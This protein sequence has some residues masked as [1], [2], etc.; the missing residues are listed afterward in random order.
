MDA[1]GVSTLSCSG[2]DR[3]MTPVAPAPTSRIAPPSLA[4]TSTNPSATCTESALISTLTVKVVP[5]TIA[6]RRGV[7]TLKCCEGFLSIWKRIEPRSCRIRV[8][9]AFDSG[10]TVIR[11]LGPRVMRCAPLNKA[12]R[13]PAAVVTILPTGRTWLAFAEMGALPGEAIRTTPATSTSFQSAA[14]ASLEPRARSAV[15]DTAS[16]VRT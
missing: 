11:L 9:P 6:A 5:F 2:A 13:P 12:A 1:R 10:A 4:R 14:N 8:M 3:A 16:A 15:K 7:S